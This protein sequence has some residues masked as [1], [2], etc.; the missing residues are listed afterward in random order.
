MATKRTSPRPSRPVSPKRKPLK[1][2]SRS[3]VT[4][5]GILLG[6]LLV[7]AAH[8]TR[9]LL[10]EASYFKLQS[11]E[12]VGAESLSEKEVL[13]MS[14]LELGMPAFRID[15]ERVVQ[16]VLRNPKGDRCLV[17][18]PTP[19]SLLI[20]ISE[21]P[22]VARIVLDGKIHE[23]G[24][25]GEIMVEADLDSETPLL[26]D[27]EIE[28]GSPR[29]LASRHRN[30]LK[31][32]L[33][34][35]RGGPTHDFTRIRFGGGGRM[36]VTWRG[37]RLVVDDPERFLNHKSF[38][39]PVIADARERGF[40]F[41]YVDLRF[42]DVVA[43]YKPLEDEEKPLHSSAVP[44]AVRPPRPLT[45]SPPPST[46][47][48]TLPVDLEEFFGGVGETE[49]ASVPTLPPRFSQAPAPDLSGGAARASASPNVRYPA[50]GQGFTP[51]ARQPYPRV[52][53]LPPASA[54][55]RS[56]QGS[57]GTSPSFG[58]LPRPR[59]VVS[60]NPVR[61]WPPQGDR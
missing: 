26:L 43:K 45:P 33:Q 18:Q 59:G 44:V 8:Q 24:P 7:Y 46:S 21:K 30:R 54:I 2:P 4:F 10:F 29:R 22:E 52:S 61:N 57:G 38:L 25:D 6:A 9:F 42:Q 19:N 15:P 14:G 41:E 27:A 31:S 37:V 13:R 53:R 23:V 55:P 28:E 58:I 20:Q 12:V 40:G 35:L 51:T 34:V 5:E 39:G 16:M 60:P 11:V 1:E 50:S 36:D 32:W 17:E 3:R 47:S 56:R 48:P 49:T